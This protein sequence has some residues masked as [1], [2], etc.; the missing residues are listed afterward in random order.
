MRNAIVQSLEIWWRQ[1]NPEERLLAEAVDLAD[2]ERRLRILE[3]RG[4]GP[5]FVTFNH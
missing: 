4:C 3:R 5:A 1:L 2:L